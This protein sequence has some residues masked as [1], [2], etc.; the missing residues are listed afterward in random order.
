MLG[1]LR[2][3]PR[4]AGSVG[5]R[6]RRDRARAG[7][8][9]ALIEWLA[10]SAVADLRRIE[11]LADDDALALSVYRPLE[12][13]AGS[14]R[15]KLY[16]RGERVLLSGVLPM[17]ESMGLEVA[18]ERPYQVSPREGA[19]TWIYD[20]GLHDPAHGELDVGAIRERFQDGF[21]RVWHGDVD[22]D[23][24][25]GLIILAGLEWRD[26]TDLR[27][28]AR[29]LR[30]AGIAFSDSYMEQTLMTHGTWPS[31]SWRC[32]GRASTRP[33]GPGRRCRGRIAQEI[34]AVE[35]FDEH[36]ILNAFLSVVRAMLRTNFFPRARTAVVQR[37]TAAPSSTKG[38][39]RGYHRGTATGV[40]ESHARAGTASTSAARYRQG[41]VGGL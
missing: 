22:P 9:A 28:T 17:F 26:V 25:N 24:L 36:R 37:Q 34:E 18:D 7:G 39:A 14:L 1:R 10:R 38:A 32:S 12:A 3:R 41:R 33:G 29:Y 16:R 4:R 19:P 23:G 30:Q 8:R 5:R 2:V 35:S 20:R 31:R 11:A 27:T 40:S 15:C 21:A 13:P 6:G